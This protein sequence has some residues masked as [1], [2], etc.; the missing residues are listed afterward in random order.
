MEYARN[1]GA[2]LAVLRLAARPA[3]NPP[4]ALWTSPTDLR[5][6]L[7]HGTSGAVLYEGCLSDL[8]SGTPV[9]LPPG[10]VTPLRLAVGLSAPTGPDRV[11]GK[12]AATFHFTVEQTHGTRHA[13]AGEG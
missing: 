6:R 4:G 12:V 13:H 3:T 10:Q 1:D 8:A 9:P 11:V 5:A 2:R 7:T